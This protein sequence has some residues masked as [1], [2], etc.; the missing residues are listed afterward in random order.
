VAL[1][2]EEHILVQP[3]LIDPLHA[4]PIH[5]GQAVRLRPRSEVR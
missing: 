5:I 3:L 1:D 4:A 2:G